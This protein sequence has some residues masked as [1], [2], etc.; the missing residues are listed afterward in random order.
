M[1]PFVFVQIYIFC[2]GL[3]FLLAELHVFFRDIQYI[4]RAVTTAWMYLTPLFYPL[5]S[6]PHA[7]QL[8]IKTCNPLYYYVAQ[9]RDLV[10]TGRLPGPRIWWGGWIIAF[11][12]FGVGLFFFH[13][14]KDRFI[15][16]I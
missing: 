8:F 15:L 7:L 10:Y 5:E 14:N 6:L 13:R 11:V 1:I 3:G 4:Y 16:Y 12:M 9:Y 2:L